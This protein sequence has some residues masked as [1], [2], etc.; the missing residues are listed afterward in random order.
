MPELIQK[1]YYDIDLVTNKLL[2]ARL[3]PVTTTERT[4]LGSS[5]NAADSGIMVYDTT[6]AGYYFWDGNAWQPN[7]LDA[8]TIAQINESYAKIVTGTSFTNT[9]TQRTLT[10]TRED[11]TVLTGSFKYAHIHTQTT[12]S[13]SWS[14]NHGLGKYPAVTIVDSAGSEVIGEVSYTDNNNLIISFTA[15]FSGKAFLN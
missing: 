12:S 8:A 15:S 3:H 2:N 14:I 13:A 6:L 5:Y 4:A 10:I 11:A 9:E 7:S 1:Y